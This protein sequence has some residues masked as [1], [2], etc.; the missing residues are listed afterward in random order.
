MFSFQHEFRKHYI[1]DQSTKIMGIVN[2]QYENFKANSLLGNYFWQLS[3]SSGRHKW[4]FSIIRQTFTFF[5]VFDD[6][7]LLK[8]QGPC[9]TYN[10]DYRSSTKTGSAAIRTSIGIAGTMDGWLYQGTDAIETFETQVSA[11]KVI[12]EANK[13]F[14]ETLGG[15]PE[16]LCD[17]R[18]PV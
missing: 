4:F 5:G 15:H 17:Q 7:D 14:G 18:R 1:V 10:R 8:L 9:L 12:Q 3:K 13:C 2:K 6:M 16:R 11:K